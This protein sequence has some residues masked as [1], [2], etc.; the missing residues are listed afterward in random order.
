MKGDPVTTDVGTAEGDL[1]FL[2]AVMEEGG[3]ARVRGGAAFVAGGLLYGLQCFVG[4]AQWLRILVLPDWLST[5]FAVGVTVVFLIVISVIAWRGRKHRLHGVASRAVAAAFASAGLA[6]LS[7][8]CV[9]GSVAIRQKSLLIW[10][11][12]PAVVCAIQGAM[13]FIAFMLRRSAWLCVVAFGWFGTAI[14][15]GFLLGTPSYALVLGFALVLLMAVPGFV[16]MHE[17]RTG[18]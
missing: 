1:A 9:F 12:Y 14:A 5:T 18:A 7:M 10:F 4:W 13:W 17:Q 16:I 3:R 15:L 2:K 11:L 8:V 6:N